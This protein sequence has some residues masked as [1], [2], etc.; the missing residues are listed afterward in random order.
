M[1]IRNVQKLSKSKLNHLKIFHKN[2][3]RIFIMEL[4][5]V[6]I[7]VIGCG[8]RGEVYSSYA[9]M[10]PDRAKVVGLCDPRVHCVKKLAKIHEKT[11]DNTKIFTDW[12]DVVNSNKKLSDCVLI[13]LPDKLH[14]DAAIEFTKKG[15][16]I[17]LEKPMATTLNDCKEITNACRSW[18]SQINAVCHVLRYYSPCIKLKQ[19]I[20]SG[21][22][23]DV[24]NINH[25]EPVG[26]W[27]FAHSFVRGNWH[28]ENESAFSLL[29]KC[30]HDIDLLVYWMGSGKKCVKVSSFGS[31]KHFRKENAPRESTDN[32]FT[33]PVEQ[34]C[35]Y[36][37]KK[38]Y[39]DPKLKPGN[40]PSSVVLSSEINHIRNDSNQVLI[41]DIEDFFLNKTDQEKLDFLERC[42]KSEKTNYGRC[43]YQMDN[44]VCD[45]Q[46]VN[47]FFDDNS[48]ATLT[49]IAFSKDTCSRKTR[50]YGTKGEL[51]WDDTVS[52]DKITHYDFLTRTSNLIDC[53]DSKPL[54]IRNNDEPVV[55]NEHIKLTGHGG[56]DYW[57]M[58]SFVEA[59]LK[60]DKSLILT[61]V[62]DS[63]RSHLIVF[64]AE[65]SRV[66]DQIVDINQ[67]CRVNNINF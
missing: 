57:L 30:C 55:K 9:L 43:V 8:S 61:D 17:L 44:D 2:F 38:L 39:L 21:L 14:R 40:W 41:D 54:N 50:V 10:H 25:I 64:A 16:H 11:V 29:A 62:E 5:I 60:N 56:S 34:N 58:D 51:E 33:C 66:K 23:G 48:T 65:Y 59:I 4:N 46:V 45:N 67:F 49:M 19:L 52:H 28:N 18:P 24:V 36:S 22:I 20:E 13:C 6:S 7:I 27:H 53:S 37:A 47:M 42:L 63:F 32:C 31:L 26:F 1:Q 3:T 35:C 12:K 15:Y